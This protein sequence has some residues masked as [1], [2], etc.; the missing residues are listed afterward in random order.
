MMVL[1]YG[2]VWKCMDM[3]MIHGYHDIY[4]YLWIYMDIL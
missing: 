4:G 2:Y 1:I 3:D